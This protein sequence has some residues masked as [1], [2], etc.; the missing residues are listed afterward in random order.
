MN[1]CKY[2]F[3]ISVFCQTKHFLQNFLFSSASYPSSYVGNNAVAT[4]L[5]ASVLHLQIRSCMLSC[6][7]KLKLF[8]FYRLVQ[9][10]QILFLSASLFIIFQH[11]QQI[12]LSVISQYNIN[13]IINIFHI[14]LCLH[15]TACCNNN[16]LWIHLSCFM[17]HLSGF[18]VCNVGYCTSID[19]INISTRCKRNNLISCFFQH[20]LHGF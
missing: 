10:Y 13:G 6:T 8:I 15:V 19:N 3:L 7:G 9:T 14:L 16:C 5:I 2:K 20:F 12:L 17:E 11:K 18:S 1:S 4:K